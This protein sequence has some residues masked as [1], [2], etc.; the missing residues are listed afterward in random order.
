MPIKKISLNLLHDASC[1]QSV[2]SKR[3]DA[4][5]GGRRSARS[6]LENGSVFNGPISGSP[7]AKEQDHL[8]KK[9][10]RKDQEEPCSF[11]HASDGDFTRL[12]QNKFDL[13]LV[14]NL[15]KIEMKSIQ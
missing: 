9:K 14:H 1:G 4:E 11:D 2:Q 7:V 13:L 12:I 3:F 10:M 5:Y 8:P 15:R 6:G